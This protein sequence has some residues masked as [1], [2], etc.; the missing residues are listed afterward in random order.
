METLEKFYQSHY[1]NGRTFYFTD[2][3]GI[4]RTCRF[5][6]NK[7]T[8]KVYRDFNPK[9]PTHGDVV[10]FDATVNIEEAL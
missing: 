2:E 9:S 5:S 3:L 7:I 6:D 10:A 1:G 4:Q 8:L